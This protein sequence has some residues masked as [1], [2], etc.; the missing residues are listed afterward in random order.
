MRYSF[1]QHFK[2]DLYQSLLRDLGR[3]LEDY[4][5]LSGS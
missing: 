3:E 1:S 2:Q 4:R 5:I